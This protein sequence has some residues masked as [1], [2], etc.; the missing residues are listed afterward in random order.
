M[1]RSRHANRRKRG[2]Q[3][4]SSSSKNFGNNAAAGAA[5][6]HNTV[7]TGQR[8]DSW[9]NT[10]PNLHRRFV[11]ANGLDARSN[12]PLKPPVSPYTA[13]FTD[14]QLVELVQKRESRYGIIKQSIVPLLL[15]GL[16]MVVAGYYL[17]HIQVCLCRLSR[18]FQ[19]TKIFSPR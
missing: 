17:H 9:V 13:G 5:S 15:A 18:C 10:P 2:Y 4:T 8:G 3:K 12:G 1:S 16:G 19:D 6:N 14:E 7:G 11:A